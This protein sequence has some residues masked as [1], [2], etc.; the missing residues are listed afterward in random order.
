MHAH[1][2]VMIKLNRFKR[3]L[4]QSTSRLYICIPHEQKIG[5]LLLYCV[6]SLKIRL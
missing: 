2:C 5:I 1:I 4:L 6:F 3:L